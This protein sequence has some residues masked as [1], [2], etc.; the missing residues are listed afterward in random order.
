MTLK[1][2]SPLASNVLLASGSNRQMAGCCV[3]NVR[4]KL[5]GSAVIWDNSGSSYTIAII[6][7]LCQSYSR[8]SINW[9]RMI[10]IK[11]C[12]GQK[13]KQSRPARLSTIKTENDVSLPRGIVI[14]IA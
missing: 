7:C 9:D 13:G 4:A 3:G 12:T 5:T 11:W 10:I 1:L 2:R 14:R 8:P 6:G